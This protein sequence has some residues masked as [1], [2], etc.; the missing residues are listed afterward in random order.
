MV[1]GNRIAVLL[2]G[3][4]GK[5]FGGQMPKQLI[6]VNEKPLFCYALEALD[7]SPVIDWVLLVVRPDLE[8]EIKTD[9]ANYYFEKPISYVSGGETRSESVHHAVDYLAENGIGDDALIL[10]QDADRPNLTSYLI[11]EGISKAEEVGASVTALPCSDSVFVSDDLSFVSSYQPRDNTF[12][13]QTPQ[14]FRLGLLKKLDF[15][16]KSTDEASQV[17]AL[18]QKVAIVKGNPDNYKINYPFDLRRFERE[19]KK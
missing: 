11:E 4:S 19:T 2:L 3:G 7:K 17:V 13:A 12:L 9:V 15:A 6:P 1:K 8:G 14:T 16:A 5:R 10:I 18:K